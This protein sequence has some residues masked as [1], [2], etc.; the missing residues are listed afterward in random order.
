MLC[1]AEAG[2]TLRSDFAST[3]GVGKAATPSAFG[4]NEKVF[5]PLL[6]TAGIK[7]PGGVKVQKRLKALLQLGTAGLKADE[8]E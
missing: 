6:G 7:G 1:P 3:T 8:E 5:A 2:S 4:R